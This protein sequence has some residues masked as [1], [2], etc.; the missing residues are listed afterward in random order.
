MFAAPLGATAAQTYTVSAGAESMGG[1]VQ[2]NEFA[3]NQITVNVGDTVTWKLN[4][5]EFHNIV[6]T[7][8]APAP[9]FVLGGP[10]G[11]FLNPVAAFPMGGP[12]YD[13]TG[14]VGSG[15]LNKGETYSL[16]FSKAGAF[17][18]LCAIHPGMGGTIRVVDNNAGV[19]T[20]AAIDARAAAQ[21]NT[22]LATRA[23][24][25]IMDNLGELQV[26]GSGAGVAAG[27]ESF[28]ADV[29]RFLPERV[30]I[31]RGQ[32][33]TWIWKTE[34]TPHTVTFLSGAPAPDI[35]IP[36]PQASGPPRLQLN[37]RVLAPIGNTA[38]W[39]GSGYLNSGFL[40]PAQGRPAPT[41]S[42]TFGAS[43]TY[44]YL[45]LLHEGMVG[46][47]VVEPEE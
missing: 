8:G 44:S 20:Q 35:I 47:V 2:V 33:V 27:V 36:Q 34:G 11:V 29:Q 30:T 4:S 10:T 15:L 31:R 5:T 41:F 23:I 38:P 24:P 43:G 16:T 13:G 3:P 18:Y 40:Q 39:T 37:P 25:V 46:T 12:S 1:D 14:L 32:A 26:E 19:D 9:E 17:N 28:S 42:V 45:C 21:V 6:F 22:T 7:S